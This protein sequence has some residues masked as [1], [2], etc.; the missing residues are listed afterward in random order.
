M[1]VLE[2]LTTLREWFHCG[3]HLQVM[4]PFLA[5]GLLA[6]GFFPIEARLFCGMFPVTP[7]KQMQ[8]PYFVCFHSSGWMNLTMSFCS[9]PAWFT[10]FANGTIGIAPGNI[11][12]P[13]KL[14]AWN[15]GEES[16]LLEGL[17]W[18]ED[19]GIEES[20]IRWL[21]DFWCRR[22]EALNVVRA[23][24]RLLLQ[25][26]ILIRDSRARKILVKWGKVLSGGILA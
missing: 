7:G 21:G 8:L 13:K 9:S 16:G 18:I 11:H 22:D 3:T 6:R 26:S 14:A 20:A 4:Q 23:A 12:P 24:V 10:V 5:L 1:P 19:W 15:N 25:I 2:L 17:A